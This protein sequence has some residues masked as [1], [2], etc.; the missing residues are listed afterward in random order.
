ML[1]DATDLKSMTGGRGSCTMKFS[2]YAEVP[3]RAAQPIIAQ[4][5]RK[6]EEARLKI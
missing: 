4:S 6:P 1:K 2:R 3:A 5:V